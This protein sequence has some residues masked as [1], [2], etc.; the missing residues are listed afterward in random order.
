[1]EAPGTKRDGQVIETISC[2]R[3]FHSA[4]VRQKKDLEKVVPERGRET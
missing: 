2:G 1:M 4:A 3:P